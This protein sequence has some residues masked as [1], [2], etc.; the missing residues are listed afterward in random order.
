MDNTAA[1]VNDTARQIEC[2]ENRKYHYFLI[3]SIATMVGMAILV[4]MIRLFSYPF[5]NRD[6]H[7]E[8]EMLLSEPSMYFHRSLS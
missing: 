8:D 4:L 5:R 1:A 2:L 7:G 3:S 6:H